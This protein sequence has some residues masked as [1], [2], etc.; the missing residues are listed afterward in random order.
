MS[1]DVLIV[2]SGF[3][4]AAAAMRLAQAGMKV[5]IVERGDR[6]KRD[7][8]D[9]DARQILITQRYRSRSP[10]SVRQYGRSRYSPLQSS[11][12][13]GGNSV[14]YGGASLRLREA[15]FAAWPISY[16][17]LEPYYCTAEEQLGVHGAEGGR[18]EPPRSRP[19]PHEPVDLATPA[20]RILN[21]GEKLGLK[22][23]RIPLAINFR[24][25]AKPL[26]I[27][28]TTCD[29]FP[30]KIEAKNDVNGTLLRAAQ[31]SGAEVVTGL[32]AD[33]F[34]EEAGRIS[35]LECVEATSGQRRQL[36]GDRYIL[37]AGAI[38]SAATLLRSGLDRFSDLLGRGL[39]RHCNAVVTGIFPFQT[40]R[41]REFHK[42]IC[43]DD[44]YEQ[45]RTL[46][47]RATGIIQ[48]IY[49]PAA[50]VIRHFAPFGAR[51]VA[52]AAT[53]YM[54]NLL[55]IAEDEPTAAN[56]VHLSPNETDPYGLPTV[57]V[58]HT[59]SEGDLR[60]RDHL[61]AGARRILKAAGALV[62]RVHEIDTFSHAIGGAP[63]GSDPEASVLDGDCRLRGVNNLWVTDGSFMPT[64]G[65][66]NPSLTITAN[67]LRVADRVADR[68]VDLT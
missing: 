65:A 59:Y 54:Q 7:D 8:D 36:R 58:D 27:R 53:K 31:S 49:T 3:G 16:E 51:H 56:R 34:L 19:Y 50:E 23:F 12:V 38:G 47:G 48:D 62:T 15:D 6:P 63:F 55:C 40:N 30:C 4:G 28:C 9:W 21:A 68:I 57:R 41:A 44:F 45:E 24:D 14:F 22:P 29:G 39:M 33:R 35:A 42:Q 13:L 37:A 18:S 20:Q 46:S 67:A 5:L 66:V 32:I 60:R 61:V 2:G 11:A 26:C 64:A 25:E 1:Y 10:L 52:G 17:E 43:F